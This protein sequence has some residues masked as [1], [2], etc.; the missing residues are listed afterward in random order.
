MTLN[1]RHRQV[2]LTAAISAY[3]EAKIKT[4]VKYADLVRHADVEV[5]KASAHHKHGDVFLCKALLE[6]KNGK[7]IRVDREAKDLYKAIDKVHDHARE[8]LTKLHRL[9][10]GTATA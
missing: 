5:G 8:E 1:I 3:V 9:E 10:L 6:L 4:L 7:Q 2:E